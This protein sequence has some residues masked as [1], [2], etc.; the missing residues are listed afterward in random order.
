[1]KVMNK[2][3]VLGFIGV[4]VM[5]FASCGKSQTYSTALPNGVYGG[6][7]DANATGQ[8]VYTGDIFNCSTSGGCMPGEIPA[9]GTIKLMIYP[10]G[11]Q[12]SG[13]FTASASLTVNGSTYCC[14]SQGSSGVLG[15]PLGYADVDATLNNLTLVC[16]SNGTGVGLF[17]GGYSAT[18]LKIGVIGPGAPMALLT[19]SAKRLVGWIQ[20]SGGIQGLSYYNMEVQ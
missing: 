9:S 7:C 17:S 19:T 8:Y 18:A 14:T 11:G 2:L 1:M 3:K 16:Q 5:V 13:Q 10:T 15:S 6:T 12:I 4:A 20:I